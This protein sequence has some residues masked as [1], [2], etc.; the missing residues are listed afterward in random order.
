MTVSMRALFTPL[1]VALVCHLADGAWHALDH[2]HDVLPAASGQLEVHSGDC[3]H[4]PEGSHAE[5]ECLSCNVRT[6]TGTASTTAV[7]VPLV[8]TVEL[9]PQRNSDRLGTTLPTG[10]LGARGPPAI[11]A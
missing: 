10:V 3:E 11:T 4:R 1:L 9:A 8:V 6:L 2:T 7:V 5:T